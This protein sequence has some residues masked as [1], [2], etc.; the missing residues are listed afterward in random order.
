[1]KVL[2]DQNVPLSLAKFLAKHRVST[3][4]G[5]GWAKLKNGD[6]LKVAEEDGF[7][8][9]VTA[10]RNLSYQQNLRG[11]SIAIVVLPSGQ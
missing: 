3:A 5:V 10:D 1:M 4:N 8:V 7:E 2:F 9:L 6:L 11:R